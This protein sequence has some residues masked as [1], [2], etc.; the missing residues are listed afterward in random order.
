MQSLKLLP[1]LTS[2]WVSTTSVTSD[3]CGG[4]VKHI[5]DLQE[6][7]PRFISKCN[8]I[9]YGLDIDIYF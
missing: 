3:I 7:V 4:L 6:R 1:L 2:P 5:H 9:L 8:I